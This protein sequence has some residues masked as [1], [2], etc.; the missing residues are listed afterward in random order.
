[1]T[2]RIELH[3]QNHGGVDRLTP[4]E[5]WIDNVPR[6]SLLPYETLAVDVDPGPHRVEIKA[7][8]AKCK[9]LTID[10][11]AGGEVRLT[12]T[13]RPGLAW[14]NSLMIGNATRLRLSR[15]DRS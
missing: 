2:G 8:D 7:E 10:V 15:S 5:L 12:L 3:R 14:F 6:G 13:S 1:M 4:A 11:P 9:S